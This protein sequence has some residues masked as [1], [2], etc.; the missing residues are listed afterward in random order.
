MRLLM[1]LQGS[2]TFREKMTEF[3]SSVSPSHIDWFQWCVVLHCLFVTCSDNEGMEWSTAACSEYEGNWSTWSWEIEQRHH[4]GEFR[5]LLS[6]VYTVN[7]CC[8]LTFPCFGALVVII[9]FSAAH[10][11]LSF[12]FIW[13]T[14][15]VIVY[16]WSLKAIPALEKVEGCYYM[17]F[18]SKQ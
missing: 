18:Y 17:I 16:H 5:L 13:N 12:R 1:A 9:M 2:L 14:F 10:S 3:S 7:L 8:W 15:S 11:L 6:S 4:C